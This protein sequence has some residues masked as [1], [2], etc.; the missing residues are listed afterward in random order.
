MAHMQQ[1]VTGIWYLAD[2]WHIED[3]QDIRPELDR[4]QALEV[5]RAMSDNFDANIGINWEYISDISYTLY[6][7]ED[8]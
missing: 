5:L 8:K 4:S 7:Q 1:D 3:I 2:I 6:P